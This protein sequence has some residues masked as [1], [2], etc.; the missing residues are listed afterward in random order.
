MRTIRHFRLALILSFAATAT[1]PAIEVERLDG[2]RLSIANFSEH[3]ATAI[4]FLS[5]RSPETVAAA[6]EIRKA[7]DAYRRQGVMFAGIFPNPAESGTEVRDFCQASGFVFPCYRDPRRTA[8]QRLG[9]KLTPEVFL[10][11]RAGTLIYSGNVSGLDA[12]LT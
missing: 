12:A 9:A 8:A 1:Q 6:T 11:D 10:F 2:S 3:R 5:S 4:V 7:N